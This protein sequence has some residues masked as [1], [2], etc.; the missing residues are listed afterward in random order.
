MWVDCQSIRPSR[1]QW[2]IL[3]LW[4]VIVL[5][6]LIT[7]GWSLLLKV[8]AVLGL[9]LLTFAQFLWRARQ[10]KLLLLQ[11]LDR[12]SW[13]WQQQTTPRQPRT[14]RLVTQHPTQSRSARLLGVEAWLG[15]VVILR[16]EVTALSTRQTWLIWCDQVDRDNWRR[17]QVLQQYWAAPL[18]D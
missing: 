18:V 9:L 14:P 3:L 12:V 11:Q 10:P 16:F 15:Q 1:A 4:C 6:V 5:G 8:I 13:Q 17:L 2:L 7:A